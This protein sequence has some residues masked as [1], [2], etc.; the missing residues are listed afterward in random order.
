MFALANAT[1]TLNTPGFS[2]LFNGFGFSGYGV[3]D[4][5]VHCGVAL[6]DIFDSTHVNGMAVS[7][8]LAFRSAV[9]PDID[10][11]VNAMKDISNVPGSYASFFYSPMQPDILISADKKQSASSMQAQKIGLAAFPASPLNGLIEFKCLSSTAKLIGT[12]QNDFNEQLA[13]FVVKDIGPNPVTPYVDIRNLSR[14]STVQP[15][16][17]TDGG[18]FLMIGAILNVK[19]IDFFTLLHP[20]R[21]KSLQFPLLVL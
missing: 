1:D 7:Y 10:V 8:P 14:W 11:R 19:G 6:S 2:F 21:L 16:I 3:T 17:L 9:H 4:N 18:T 5:G 20:P 12:L 13:Y 15:L